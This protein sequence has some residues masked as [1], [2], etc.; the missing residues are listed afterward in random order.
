MKFKY[1]IPKGARATTLDKAIKLAQG[2]T[3]PRYK[4]TVEQV[5]ELAVLKWLVR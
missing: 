4:F 3:S 5:S 1:F 2:M